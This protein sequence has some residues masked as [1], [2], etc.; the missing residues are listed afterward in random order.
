MQKWVV[1][2]C[3]FLG[4]TVASF[5][6]IQ[7]HFDKWQ[8]PVIKPWIMSSMCQPSKPACNHFS[9]VDFMLWVMQFACFD[10]KTDCESM[11]KCKKKKKNQIMI[12]TTKKTL[13]RIWWT[14]SVT[15]SVHSWVFAILCDVHAQSFMF[16]P[17][18][19][20][21]KMEYQLPQIHSQKI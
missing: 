21:T 11:T 1:H 2:M 4:N 7:N 9:C 15:K 12:W 14:L 8:M 16:T 13:S 6:A 10:M 18:F 5:L 3:Q 17:C 20:P 19:H